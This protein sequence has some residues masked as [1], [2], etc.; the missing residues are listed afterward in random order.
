M[1]VQKRSPSDLP[2]VIPAG[3]YF[4]AA[5]IAYVLGLG[6]CFGVNFATNAAQPAL[7]YLVPALISSTLI[8]AAL[9]GELQ[10]VLQFRLPPRSG[11]SIAQQDQQND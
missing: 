3:P 8:V 2:A 7:L 4:Y 6:S 1:I 5:I 11:V 10:D 9:R